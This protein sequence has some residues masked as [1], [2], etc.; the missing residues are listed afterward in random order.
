MI[1]VNIHMPIKITFDSKTF[2]AYFTLIFTNATVNIH[3]PIKITFF[4][5]TFLT[6]FTLIFT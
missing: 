4:S 1:S 3:M 2:L 5:K 6:Y